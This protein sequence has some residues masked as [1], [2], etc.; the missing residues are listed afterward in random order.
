M[1][2]GLFQDEEEGA[3]DG[4]RRQTCS[5]TKEIICLGNDLEK[6]ERNKEVPEEQKRTKDKFCSNKYKNASKYP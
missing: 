1:Y 3:R 2:L 5:V 6:R 4:V